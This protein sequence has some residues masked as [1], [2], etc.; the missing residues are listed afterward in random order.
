M[1]DINAGKLWTVTRPDTDAGT[2]GGSALR[3]RVCCAIPNNHRAVSKN[4]HRSDCSRATP[5][6]D[7][8][9]RKRRAAPEF[10]ANGALVL[11]L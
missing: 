1:T 3:H 8:T 10:T 6:Q 9:I 7:T 11:R 2:Q 5:K 4:G